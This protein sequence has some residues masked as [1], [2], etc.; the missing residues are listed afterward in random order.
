M[1]EESL[2]LFVVPSTDSEDFSTDECD[3]T[4]IAFC[5]RS[6]LSVNSL[7]KRRAKSH[8]SASFSTVESLFSVASSTVGRSIESPV[9]DSISA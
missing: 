6:E 8:A 3:A 1:F 4:G 5:G 9:F 2:T 7:I